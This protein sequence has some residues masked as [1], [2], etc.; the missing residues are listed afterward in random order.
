[1]D[2]NTRKRLIAFTSQSLRQQGIRAV[3][4]DVVAREMNMSKRTLYK[5]YESK[6]NLVN[7][8]LDAYA[9]R[10]GNLFQLM[11]CNHP[12]PLSLLGEVSQAFVQ[13]LYKAD[14]AFWSDIAGS[15]RHIYEAIHNLWCEE[16]ERNLLS[17]KAECLVIPGL[18]VE[19]LTT[20]FM[21]V[22]RQARIMEC[23]QAML[24]DSAYF[25]LRGILTAKGLQL[26]KAG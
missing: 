12:E 3:R 20:S 11:K 13:M 4:M 17:C 23:P 6:D 15:Y 16:L 8:C 26:F 25:M 22:L 9:A 24:H 14:C 2:E 10:I 18:D 21:T 5:V 19:K 1:M 7:A